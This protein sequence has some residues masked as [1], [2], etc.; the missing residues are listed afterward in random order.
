MQ[1]TSDTEFYSLSLNTLAPPPYSPR[2]EA[3]PIVDVESGD[4]K[5]GESFSK[6]LVRRFTQ[7]FLSTR[8][9]QDGDLHASGAWP[10][11]ASRISHLVVDW[12]LWELLSWSMSALCILG[13]AVLL[14]YWNE[15]AVPDHWPSGIT[16]NAYIAVLS[17][18]AKYAL[19]VPV[20]A[21]ISQTKWH[22]F[23]Q[24]ARPLMDLEHFDDAS[25][26]P[27]GA[28]KLMF[29]IKFKYTQ[30]PL[31]ERTFTYTLSG[32]SPRSEP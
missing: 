6:G 29:R 4:E 5:S 10:N 12:W 17:G 21:S 19:A 9:Q 25:R 15:R 20:E 1:T 13:I 3:L 32:L 14:A 16:L 27:F 23:A 18:I 30:T 7:P 2:A 26:G 11:A 24:E 8:S 31:L 28:L 22:W